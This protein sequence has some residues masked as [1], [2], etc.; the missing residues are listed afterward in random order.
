MSY[1]SVFILLLLVL[2]PTAVALLLLFFFRE[3]AK[4]KSWYNDSHTDYVRIGGSMRLSV[5]IAQ[6]TE[7]NSKSSP[8][9]SHIQTRAHSTHNCT[10]AHS[11]PLS[12]GSILFISALCIIWAEL[13]HSLSLVER[14]RVFSLPLTALKE[15][16]YIRS[17]YDTRIHTTKTIGTQ[18][19][20]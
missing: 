7:L 18:I 13:I 10:L 11:S 20:I 12:V 8:C 9:C 4:K 1:G 3:G 5:E 2:P 6:A 16:A 14:A 15:R 19:Y 17:M